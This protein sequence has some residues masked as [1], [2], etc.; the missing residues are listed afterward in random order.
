MAASAAMEALYWIVVVKMEL[1][2][3]AK[4]LIYQLICVPTATVERLRSLIQPAKMSFK[5]SFPSSLR[6]NPATLIG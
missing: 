5:M 6:L 2:Q 1:S 3:M 4:L